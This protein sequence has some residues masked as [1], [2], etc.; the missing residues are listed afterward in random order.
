[1]RPAGIS[2]DSRHL[3]PHGGELLVLCLELRQLIASGGRKVENIERDYHEGM[4]LQEIAQP[5]DRPVVR[6][7]R[8]LR[9]N[10]AEFE[11]RGLS[12]TLKS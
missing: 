5:N 8:K 4:I 2:R 7:K 3:G 10:R 12:V 1:M 6:R 9:D 11:H